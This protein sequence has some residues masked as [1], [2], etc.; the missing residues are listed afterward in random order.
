MLTYLR[1]P[2]LALVALCFLC[3]LYASSQTMG[4]IEITVTLAGQPT[5]A[6]V[7]VFKANKII[8]AFYTDVHAPGRVVFNLPPGGYELSIEHGAG[9]T[10]LPIVRSVQLEAEKTL[11]VSA[12][13]ERFFTPKSWNYYSAD[14]HAHTFASAAAHKRIFN[15]DNHGVTPVD[16]T[17][18]VL[19]GADLDVMF[20]SDHNSTDGHELFAKTSQARHVPFVL[21]EEITTI[22]WGHWNPMPLPMNGTVEYSLPDRDPSHYFSESRTK[23]ATLIQA[24]HPF[25]S[26]FGYFYNLDRAGFDSS[27]DAIEVMNGPFGQ[28]DE[29]T[30]QMIFEFWNEGKRYVATAVSDDHDWKE[31]QT[32][33]GSARTYV[34]VDGELTSEKWLASLKAGRAFVTHGPLVRFQANEKFMPGDTLELSAGESLKLRADLRSVTPLKQ[35]QLIKDGEILQTFAL[36]GTEALIQFSES[37]SSK[38]WYA[39]RVYAEDGDQALTNPIG[40]RVK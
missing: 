19:L 13:I 27:F 22:S 28:S 9:Y 36:Q 40:V 17:V 33:Y 7:R 29:R 30:I 18:G 21:S 6:W 12:N 37:P 16:Q 23:G 34:Y 38:S 24:N 3:G 14:L 26:N 11:A 5:D 8:D 2:G 32:W 10:S 35:A 31:L 20:I 25:S 39:L 4:R 15:I 1:Y